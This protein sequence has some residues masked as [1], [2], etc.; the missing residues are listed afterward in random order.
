M[1]FLLTLLLCVWPGL[2]AA[3]ERV[4]LRAAPA[5]RVTGNAQGAIRSVLRGAEREKNQI[6]IVERDG[7]YFWASREDRELTHVE[8]G[9]FHLYI[10]QRG[11]GYVKVLDQRGMSSDLKFDG[12]DLQYFEHVAAGL[13]TITYWGQFTR[14]DP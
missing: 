10:D 4:V 9:L 3:Q 5:S 8:S 11:G 13:S 6:L 1:R 14:F 7:R 2:A 12:P